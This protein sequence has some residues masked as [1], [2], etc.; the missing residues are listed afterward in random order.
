MAACEMKNYYLELKLGKWHEQMRI[1]LMFLKVMPMINIKEY[2]PM[3]VSNQMKIYTAAL[4]C[5]QYQKTSRSDD[6]DGVVKYL[7]EG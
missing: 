6:G 5:H 1:N 4:V 3:K 7:G 2:W